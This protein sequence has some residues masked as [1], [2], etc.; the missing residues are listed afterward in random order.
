M[1]EVVCRVRSSVLVAFMN[2]KI[3]ASKVAFYEKLKGLETN[4]SR[5]LV[6][7]IAQESESLIREINGSN[8]EVLPGYRTKYLDGNCIE[9]SEHRLKILR[10]ISS[11]A[12]P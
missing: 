7:Y 2:S 8:P 11:G 5:E 1:I 6:R 12:L 3:G 4:P 9:A 10:G